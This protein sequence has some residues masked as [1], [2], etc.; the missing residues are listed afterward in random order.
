VH[1]YSH[2]CVCLHV[3][4]HACVCLHVHVHACVC[5]CVYVFLTAFSFYNSVYLFALFYSGL[6]VCL[7]PCLLFREKMKENVQLVGGEVGRI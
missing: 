1:V 5:L 6:L 7:L 3:H 2:A 4:V